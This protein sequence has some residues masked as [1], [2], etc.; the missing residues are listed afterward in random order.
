MIACSPRVHSEIECGTVAA[1]KGRSTV[2]AREQSQQPPKGQSSKGHASRASSAKGQPEKG[3]GGKGKGSTL[4]SP[5]QIQKLLAGVDYPVQK[6]QLIE[7]ARKEGA[8]KE[9]LEVLEALPERE[10][11][12][13]V[14][15]S[16]ELGKLKH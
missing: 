13:P 14:S 8:G 12:S 6:G 5:V 11:S 1:A 4:E 3:K 7:Q 10:Y 15:V 16:K 9:I 2:M